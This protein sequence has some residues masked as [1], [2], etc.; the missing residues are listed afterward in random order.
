MVRF[1]IEYYDLTL[2]KLKTKSIESDN[3]YKAVEILKNEIGEDNI[4]ILFAINDNG[5]VCYNAG[6]S[7]R[8]KYGCF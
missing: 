3:F 6:I 8:V 4:E 5:V 1:I 2:N 7:K